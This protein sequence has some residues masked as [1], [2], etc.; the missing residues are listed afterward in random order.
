M[1]RLIIFLSV[2]FVLAFFSN[3]IHSQND[4]I[5]KIALIIAGNSSDE[6]HNI[7]SLLFEKL[8]NINRTNGYYKYILIDKDINRINPESFEYV[9]EI[10][11][12][13]MGSSA[14]TYNYVTYIEKKVPL[15]DKKK[16]DA[17]KK[18]AK[19]DAKKKSTDKKEEKK[20]KTVKVPVYHSGVKQSQSASFTGRMYDIKTGKYLNGFIVDYRIS[21]DF[22][23]LGLH[24]EI[25]SL[26]KANKAKKVKNY[27]KELERIKQKYLDKY[28]KQINRNK[29]EFKK[30]FVSYAYSKILYNTAYPFYYP[31]QIVDVVKKS[32]TKAKVVKLSGNKFLQDQKV[33]NVCAEVTDENGYK[34]YKRIAQFI[35]DNDLRNQN[36]AKV[37]FSKKKVLKA[38]N[39]KQKMII[40]KYSEEGYFVDDTITKKYT[41]LP[42]FT[43]KPSSFL[44]Y[45]VNYYLNDIPIFE[46]L[47]RGSLKNIK[48][49]QELLKSDKA[50]D[51]NSAFE[52][53]DKLKGA[54]YV[55]LFES[56]PFQK[57][58]T[59][60][61]E[62]KTGKVLSEVG[63]KLPVQI[64]D[65]INFYNLI[66]PAFKINTT[67]VDIAKASK[68]KANRVYI[69]SMFPLKDNSKYD[70]FK[71]VSYTVNG[72]K[73]DRTI[74]LGEIKIKELYSRTFALASVKDG[75]KDILKSFKKGER[76]VCLPKEKKKKGFL[77]G[78]FDF[79]FDN[80]ENLHIF[81]DKRVHNDLRLSHF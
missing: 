50:L 59:K 57:T 30:K 35:V 71:L 4:T 16:K 7:K 9:M 47:D 29:V 38:W 63:I 41:I 45:K 24:D 37:R 48:E 53:R 26:D 33:D 76:I 2:F 34:K 69:K 3:K 1:K 17:K 13:G 67:I 65:K 78:L 58:K 6:D 5:T 23:D 21:D 22:Q 40:N 52:L 39:N 19:K 20:Y 42:V 28:K 66:V 18:D 61:I 72:E 46:V 15:E 55:V 49:I 64:T 56:I 51:D 60:L 70:V 32:K 44:L 25:A 8:H 11:S 10:G 27:K 79:K 12:T 43:T 14:D 75:G 74:K 31:Q 77:A 62:T 36:L 81:N 54:D 73:L 80:Y 68:T